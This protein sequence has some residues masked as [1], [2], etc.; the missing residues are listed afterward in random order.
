ML[1]IGCAYGLFLEDAR[2]SAG[3]AFRTLPTAPGWVEYTDA[4]PAAM[5]YA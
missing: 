3:I 2:H 4:L 1:E 5:E